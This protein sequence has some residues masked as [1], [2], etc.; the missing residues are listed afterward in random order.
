MNI[1]IGG[2]PSCTINGKS[3]F[4][5]TDFI[6]ICKNDTEKYYWIKF[7]LFGSYRNEDRLNLIVFEGVP[8]YE[9]ISS[10][11]ASENTSQLSNYTNLLAIKYSEPEFILEKVEDITDY[12]YF[13][14]RESAQRNMRIALGLESERK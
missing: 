4:K 10:L 8:E 13:K 9:K 6:D 1:I 5:L 3:I 2:K 12:F 11:L 7:R 14:G